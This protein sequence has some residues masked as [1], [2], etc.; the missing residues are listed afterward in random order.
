MESIKKEN[1]SKDELTLM[2]NTII[3]VLLF[4][5][6]LDLSYESLGAYQYFIKYIYDKYHN[7]EYLQS[8]LQMLANYCNL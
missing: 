8:S 2:E 6:S 5:N 7:A 4:S 1:F 3:K